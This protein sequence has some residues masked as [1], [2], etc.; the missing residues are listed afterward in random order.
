MT[1]MPQTEKFLFKL[2]IFW[3]LTAEKAKFVCYLVVCDEYKRCILYKNLKILPIL[4][5]KK[6]NSNYFASIGNHRENPKENTLGWK[7]ILVAL[8]YS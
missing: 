8:Y 2:V 1:N 3:P 4:K 7:S 5:K 6:M